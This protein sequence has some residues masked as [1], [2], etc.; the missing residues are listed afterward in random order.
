MKRH[1]YDGKRGA[2]N[3]RRT[4]RGWWYE[5]SSS[6]FIERADEDPERY[7]VSC[8]KAARL[9]LDTPTITR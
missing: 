7:C 1:W 4:L 3:V 8:L 9:A 6:E 2:C 5:V